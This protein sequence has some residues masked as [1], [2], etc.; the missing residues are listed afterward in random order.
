MY[1]ILSGPE[2]RNSRKREAPASRRP[3]SPVTVATLSARSITPRS[4]PAAT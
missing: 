1:W 4:G 3:P 2:M